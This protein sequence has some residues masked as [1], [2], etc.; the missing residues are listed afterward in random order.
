MAA[1]F[2]VLFWQGR[3][4]TGHDRIQTFAASN[5]FPFLSSTGDHVTAVLR[6]DA[7]A[8]QAIRS[9]FESSGVPPTVDA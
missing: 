8:I 2:P 9:F 5:G 4:D 1:R 6:P 7:E 3:G